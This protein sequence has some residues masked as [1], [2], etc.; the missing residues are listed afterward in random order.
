[1]GKKNVIHCNIY[2]WVAVSIFALIEGLRWLRG[3]DYY[4]YYHL[5]LTGK[6]WSSSVIKEPLFK[7]FINLVSSF[8]IHPTFAFILLSGLLIASF[9]LVIKRYKETAFIALPFFF[10]LIGVSAENIVRQYAAT[11]FLMLA[12]KYYLDENKRAM[13]FF[14]IIAFLT[15]Y[16]AIFG[17]FMFLFLK[18]EF[19]PFKYPLVYV[20]VYIIFYFTWNPEWLDIFSV[21]LIEIGSFIGDTG[22]DMD[23]YLE[24]ADFWFTEKS[25]LSILDRGSS[26][27]GFL[28]KAV[29]VLANSSIIYYGFT[30]CKDNKKL[31]I[32]FFFSYIALFL[33]FMTGRMELLKRFA[34]F[35][36]WMMP[37][38]VGL[39]FSKP[40]VFK[41]NKEKYICFAFI[42]L[43]YAYYGCIHYVGT[44]PL[45]GC[46]FI[47][48]K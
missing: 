9:G 48:D 18:Q 4:N 40:N 3:V 29:Q 10:L 30:V 26:G 34:L 47:W 39:I 25:S 2:Y 31:H 41:N 14:L 32:V 19:I 16:A 38:M 22:T 7:G 21:Y 28:Y 20:T 5:F 46:G 43:N 12:Y 15:H 1:M 8:E 36:N 45:T 44:R 17:V 11:S 13:Y 24:N 42:F 33:L 6:P 37:F 27:P 23:N 35:L